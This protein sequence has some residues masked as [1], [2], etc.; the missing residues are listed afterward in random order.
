MLTEKN[1]LIKKGYY[2][3]QAT[4]TFIDTENKSAEDN[5]TDVQVSTSK[6]QAGMSCHFQ[7]GQDTSNDRFSGFSFM[8]MSD[9]RGTLVEDRAARCSEKTVREMHTKGLQAFKE[10]FAHLFPVTLVLAASERF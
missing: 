10:K 6:R 7:F 3:W 4:T 5:P 2:G 8:M 1:T 9:P